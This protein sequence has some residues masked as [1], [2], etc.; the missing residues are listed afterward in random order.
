[1]ISEKGKKTKKGENLSSWRTLSLSLAL[2][3]KV[4]YNSLSLSLGVP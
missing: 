2:S 1:M 4:V 3:L